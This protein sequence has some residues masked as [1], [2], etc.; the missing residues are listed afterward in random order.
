MK[1]YKKSDLSM[2]NGYLINGDSDVV[3]V[4]PAVVRQAN[5]LET[6]V[7]KRTW[8]SDQPEYCAGP[9]FD[10]FERVSANEE[11]KVKFDIDTPNIDAKVDETLALIGELDNIEMTESLNAELANFEKLIAF[12]NSD[13]V[14]DYNNIAAPEQFDCPTMG[15]PI[16]WTKKSVVANVLYCFELSWSDAVDG[17]LEETGTKT[18]D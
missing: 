14:M 2:V 1:M 15:N 17:P 12:A 4:D 16:E 8:V 9:D 13:M 3:V 5:R 11:G 6:M 7:Q 18:E 10:K